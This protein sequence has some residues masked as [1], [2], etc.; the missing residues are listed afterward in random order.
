ML[1]GLRS[2]ADGPGSDDA[3]S[4]RS[5]VRDRLRTRRADREFRL[6]SYSDGEPT[7]DAPQH[8]VCIV[9]DA[10]RADAVDESLTPYLASMPGTAAVSPSTWTFP[11]VAS[12]LSG[13]YPTP[14]GL[15]AGRTTLKTQLPI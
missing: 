9:V 12:L 1:E 4:V 10:L 6:R 13:R 8:V 7:T 11:A 15:S 14:T 5:V 2:L 3:A